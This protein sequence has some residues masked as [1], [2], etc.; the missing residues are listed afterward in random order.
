MKPYYQHLYNHIWKPIRSVFNKIV[1]GRD[2]DDHF[3]N[4]P[5]AIY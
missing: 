2:D 5:W 3:F 1:K 4:N